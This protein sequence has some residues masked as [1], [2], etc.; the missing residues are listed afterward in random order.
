MGKFVRLPW[1]N[2]S[3]LAMIRDTVDQGAV[4][5]TVRRRDDV[6]TRRWYTLH[7]TGADEKPHGAEASD[8]QLLLRRAAEIEQ[9]ARLDDPEYDE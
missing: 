5:L 8:L 4:T 9:M 1:V 6:R 3:L 7:W 2:I